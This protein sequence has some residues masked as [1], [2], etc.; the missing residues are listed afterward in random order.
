MKRIIF[1]SGTLLLSY[2][3]GASHTSTEDYIDQWKI[4]AV[5]QMNE[6]AIPASITLAQG[7][8]ESASGN[9]E[10]ARNANNHF[11]I[12]CHKNWDGSQFF[13]D[14]D[15]RNECF[16]SYASA[17]Q[18]YDDHSLFLTSRSRYDKL[19]TYKVTDY[20]SWA[21]GLKSAGY[22]TNPKYAHLLID[23][24]EKY[25]LDQYDRM[26]NLPRNKNEDEL[27]VLPDEGV[28]TTELTKHLQEIQS[29]KNEIS[30]NTHDVLRNKWDIRYIRVK[31]GDTYYRIAN[32]FKLGL[33]QLYKYND[34]GKRDVLHEGEVIYLDPKRRKARRG[35]NVFLCMRETTL[36]DISQEEGLKL[37]K[38]M[39]LNYIPDPDKKLP[40]G[41]KVILR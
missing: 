20:K 4:T 5:E 12:K 30:V 29:T 24:I 8:L 32:E 9:S 38:L 41:T 7:I 10:L 33:W 15:M 17:A 1:I 25:N 39:K 6:F 16:R 13:M 34:L 31:Q 26:P 23:L 28:A 14:D 11:G 40:Q 37:K 35:Y 22:A 27:S 21:K 19:F 2:S 36:R 3:A 18:S